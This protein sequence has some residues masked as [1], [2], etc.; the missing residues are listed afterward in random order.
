MLA[1]RQASLRCVFVALDMFGGTYKVERFGGKLSSSF[2][3]CSILTALIV[4]RRGLLIVRVSRL[5]GR[6]AACE[7]FKANVVAKN[8]VETFQVQTV[9]NDVAIKHQYCEIGHWYTKV[10]VVW[11]YPNTTTDGRSHRW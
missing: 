4:Q 6:T 7:R 11:N 2:S 9:F 3:I 10:A 5:S 1:A 8:L